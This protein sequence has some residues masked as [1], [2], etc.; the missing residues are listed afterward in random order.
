MISQNIWQHFYY[1]HIRGSWLSLSIYY[2]IF[3]NFCYLKPINFHSCQT[4]AL[5]QSIT[6]FKYQSK[7]GLLLR[8]EIQIYN[9]KKYSWPYG[10]WKF[11]IEHSVTTRQSRIDIHQHKKMKFRCL[12]HILDFV[13]IFFVALFFFSLD[14]SG[15]SN[16]YQLQ[17]LRLLF[18]LKWYIIELWHFC[19]RSEH[20][21]V[22][23]VFF[24]H[25]SYSNI[26]SL[27]ILV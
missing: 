23:I 26:K 20:S 25:C 19:L 7:R 6:I 14:G 10:H 22:E 2:L 4:P 1:Q 13:V 15:S 16:C 11:I 24:L 9:F 21:T 8:L 17:L 12:W 5:W 27:S 18:T 3:L